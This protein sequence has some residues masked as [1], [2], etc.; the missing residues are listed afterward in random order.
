[1][2]IESPTHS[3]VDAAL[4]TLPAILPILDFSTIKNELFPVIAAVFSKTSSLGIKVRGLEAFVILAGGSPDSETAN[5]GLDGI[6][7]DAKKKSAASALDKYTIQ[8]KMVPLIR[9]IKTKEPAVMMAA[10]KVLRQIGTVVDTEYLAMEVLPILW[11]MSLGPLLNLQQFKA[12]IELIKSL[13]TRAETEHTKKLQEMGGGNASESRNDDIMS[14]GTISGFAPTNGHADA[15]EADFEM[16]VQGKVTSNPATPSLDSAWD[17]IPNS[18]SQPARPAAP[19]GPTF[20]WSTPPPHSNLNA[21][22]P[23]AQP[24]RTVTPDLSAFSALAPSQTQYSQPLQPQS[25]SALYSKPTMQPQSASA[26]SQPQQQQPSMNWSTPASPTPNPWAAT[27]AQASPINN[28]F[29]N[30]GNSMSNLNIASQRPAVSS[31]YSS[32][33]LPPPPASPANA[34]GTSMNNSAFRPPQQQNVMNAFAAPPLQPQKQQQQ[35]NQSA[36]GQPPS[37]SSKQ[38]LDKWESL[39]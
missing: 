21:L 30:L 11:T 5:D 3:L 18:A 38:G 1:M 28:A 31:N 26:F 9:A 4:R 16:L 24:S 19:S 17:T 14:F 23:Q 35:Q 37:Q 22:R 8:E 29:P 32:F 36:F 2:A 15:S 25:A 10:L 7:V 6:M 12:F 39:L 27:Q 33:S 20:S 34:S 13:S